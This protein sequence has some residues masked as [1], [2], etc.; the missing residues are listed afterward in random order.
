MADYSSLSDLITS[1]KSELS[2]LYTSTQLTAAD[3]LY[4]AKA[5]VEIGSMLGVN[6]IVAATA[7]SVA[8]ITTTK[9]NSVNTVN[10]TRDAGVAAI[11]AAQDNT[12]V[13]LL[14]DAY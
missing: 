3:H 10:A 11:N 2:A 14:L 5:L 4:V 12:V 1:F 13:A 7:D 8:T 9:T 6:D